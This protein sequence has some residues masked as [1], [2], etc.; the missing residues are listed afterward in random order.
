MSL[1]G[2]GAVVIWHDIAPEGL[3]DFY[4]WHTQEHMPERVGIPGFARG[5]RYIAE[6]GSPE[7]FT[8]YEA[9]SIETLGGQDYLNRLNNPTPWTSRATQHFRNVSRSVQRVVYSAGPGIGGHLYSI[10]LETGDPAA[11]SENMITKVLA[12]LST[13][14]GITGVHLCQTDAAVSA[15]MTKEKEGRD[16]STGIPG[17]TLMVEGGTADIVDEMRETAFSDARLTAAG[18]AEIN[19][20]ALYRLEYIR[21]KTA[22]A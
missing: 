11:F 22:F 20:P 16:G 12:P 7:Y 13:R 15:I 19:A 1:A 17:W 6:H 3:Q 10:Q 21:N 8:L 18:A 9:I 2:E 4:A 5:R 14:H